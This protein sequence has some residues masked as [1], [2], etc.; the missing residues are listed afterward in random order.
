MK[1]PDKTVEKVLTAMSNHLVDNEDKIKSDK[2]TNKFAKAYM[3]LLKVA[4]KQY[5]VA[6]PFFK[7][8]PYVYYALFKRR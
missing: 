6:L 1:V 3:E 5:H 8:K 4:S 7:V 2:K